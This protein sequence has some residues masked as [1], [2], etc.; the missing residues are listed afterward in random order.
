VS[1]EAVADEP[2]PP[3][4]A[5]VFVPVPPVA[6]AVADPLAPPKHETFVGVPIDATKAV[7]CVMVVVSV[8]VQPLASVIVTVYVPAANPELIAAVPPLLHAYVYAVVPPEAEAVADP[9][10]APLQLT[11][12]GVPMAAVNT[13][14]CVIVTVSV[15][16]QPFASV[17]VTVNVPAASPVTAEVV[18]PVLHT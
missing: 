16:V 10:D 14:G 15:S 2:P 1:E 8:S 7:G 17:T 13:V 4:Q 11:L 9:S 18:A 3:D 12:V 5:Y 6:D